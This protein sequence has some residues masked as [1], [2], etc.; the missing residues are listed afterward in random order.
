MLMA[1][2]DAER[3][4]RAERY[5]RQLIAALEQCRF[6]TTLWQRPV[7]EHLVNLLFGF[8]VQSCGEEAAR[9]WFVEQGRSK[10]RREKSE[11][12]NWLLLEL[13]DAQK[14]AAKTSGRTFSIA[15]FIREQVEV[16]KTRPLAERRGAGG[17]DTANLR[18]HLRTLRVNRALERTR[19]GRFQAET[20][21]ADLQRIRKSALAHA[22]SLIVI[23]E[24]DRKIETLRQT[25]VALNDRIAALQSHKDNIG[26]ADI[27]D[28]SD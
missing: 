20:A 26:P 23:Q 25:L 18:E 21:L 22:D 11:I 24:I 27:Q 19:A 17:T 10:E 4:Q 8:L 5:R 14:E 6:D 9:H 15:Q 12:A 2:D 16:I 7:P 1:D 28:F 13:Y 3:L